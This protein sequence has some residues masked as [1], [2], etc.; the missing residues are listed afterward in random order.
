MRGERLDRRVLVDVAEGDFDR[1]LGAELGHEP[2]R[3]EGVAA[4]GA[5]EVVVDRD[6][7]VL[8]DAREDAEHVLLQRVAR[9]SHRPVVARKPRPGGREP[10]PVDLAA[11]QGG[12]GAQD[13]EERGHHVAGQL[14]RQV[15]EERGAVDARD[16]IPRRDVGREVARAVVLVD[17]HDGGPHRRV[18]REDRFDLREL[19][20]VAA[21]FH[22]IVGAAEKEKLA[23]LPHAHAIAGPIGAPRAAFLA[24]D[25]DEVRFGE[26]GLAEVSAS[27]ARAG[28]EKLAD[29]A[30]GDR[31][32]GFAEDRQLVAAEGLA[33]GDLCAGTALGRGRVHRRLGRA[34]DVEHAAARRRPS[35]DHLGGAPLAADDEQAHRRQRAGDHRERCRHGREH[36]GAA[37]RDEGA[38]LVAHRASRGPRRD[39]QRGA[40]REGHP[41]LFDAAVE[42]EGEALENAVAVGEPDDVVEGPNEAHH[43][44][45]LGHHSFGLAGRARGVEHV[46]EVGLAQ[47][48]G[49]GRD[50]IRRLRLPGTA[51]VVH[52]DHAH[53]ELARDVAERSFAHHG[54][55]AP[56]VQDVPE[57]IGRVGRIERHVRGARLEE[58]EDGDDRVGRTFDEQAHEVAGRDAPRPDEAREAIRALVEIAV[59]DGRF[60]RDDRRR[61][62]KQ[63]GARFE[64]VVQAAV[65]GLDG[66]HAGHSQ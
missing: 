29:L 53:P 26:L 28:Y 51:G 39:D 22:L 44:P 61:L 14:R 5:E 11:G 47:A 59:G 42:P 57:A 17:R 7:V 25:R 27:D 60:A 10:L 24:G 49:L 32:M 30:F 40:V 48:D 31:M 23:V 8:Q 4:E 13:F 6:R 36:G 12:E 9:L 62:G 1:A 52:F 37:R 33:D 55:D 50:A 41:H 35:L 21:D 19:D 58:G 65:H 56:L 54:R 34:V 3:E 45:V 66:A 64:D 43:V 2:R 63:L 18:G 16:R 38:E 46:R 20:P 15:V